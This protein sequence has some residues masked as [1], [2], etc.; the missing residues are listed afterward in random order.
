[1]QS[2]RMNL[3]GGKIEI[4]LMGSRFFINSNAFLEKPSAD[5]D[6]VLSVLQGSGK[7]IGEEKNVLV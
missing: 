5:D 2:T 4:P 7:R 1:M 3:K 6:T